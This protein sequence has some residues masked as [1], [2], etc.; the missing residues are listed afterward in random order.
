MIRPSNICMMPHISNLML[1]DDSRHNCRDYN[2]YDV[3]PPFKPADSAHSHYWQP[4]QPI[5]PLLQCQKCLVTSGV[6]LVSGIKCIVSVVI[7][8]GDDADHLVLRFIITIFH[9][10]FADKIDLMLGANGR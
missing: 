1:S 7:F 10:D 6:V 4:L 5:I 3:F 2:K 8:L 9:Q